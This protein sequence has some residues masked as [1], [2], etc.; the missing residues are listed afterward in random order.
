MTVQARVL[1]D[2]QVAVVLGL[3]ALTVRAATFGNPVVGFDEQFYLLVGERMLQG[4]VPY[5]DIWDRKPVGLFLVYAFSAL[6][7]PDPFLQY[8]LVATGFVAGTA[9]ALYRMA[10]RGGAR[11]GGALVAAALYVLWLNLSEG[12]AGQ[13]PVFYNLPVA[14]AALLVQSAFLTRTHVVERGCAAMLLAGAAIQM[15]YTAVFEGVF[16]GLALMRAQQLAGRSMPAV[17]GAGVVWAVCGLLPTALATAYF[18][19]IGALDTFVFANFS[20][21]F[22]KLPD[23][24]SARVEGL[25]TICAILLPLGAVAFAQAW[26]TRPHR[27]ADVSFAGWWLAAAVF[28]FVA[29]GNFLSPGNA[30]PI[31]APLCLCT[32]AFFS[33]AKRRKAVATG[34]IVLA[35][36]AGQ[37]LIGIVAYGKGGREQ[38]LAVAAAARPETGCIWVY[39]GYP[40]LYMLTHSCLPSRWVF[41]GHLNTANEGTAAA[42][43]VD[44]LAEV[45]RILAT[46]PEV[47]VD[48]APAYSLG[49]PQTRA[50]VQAVLARDYHLVLRVR[51]GKARFRMVYR[52]NAADDVSPLQ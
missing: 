16:L 43:G 22:G 7:G 28:G 29:F 4:A 9:F 12:E 10:V 47:I 40:A 21:I 33:T 24:V 30:L 51:T 11:P 17:L 14:L 38:A 20:S 45:Q 26:R 46:K 42:I 32:A 6:I 50:A 23:P 25:L 49:N 52:L 39:D 18:W 37:L 36:L 15:K 13:S 8:K 41:P 35:A 19:R 3:L 44:P 2:W 31:I 34:L 1:R 5:V 27:L 48:D